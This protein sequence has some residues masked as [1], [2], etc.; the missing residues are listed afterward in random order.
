[1]AEEQQSKVITTVAAIAALVFFGGFMLAAFPGLKW[2]FGIGG[3]VI[4]TL[5]LIGSKPTPRW[6]RGREE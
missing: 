5:Y 2:V 4:W 6:R 3:L 1:M